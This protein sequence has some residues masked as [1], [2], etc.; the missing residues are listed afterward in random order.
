MMKKI[1]FSLMLTCAAG[2]AH[3]DDYTYPYLVLVSDDGTQT[4]LAVEQLELTFSDGLLVAKNAAGT[5][6]FTLSQLRKMAFSDSPGV[7]DAINTIDAQSANDGPADIYT[8]S[9]IHAGTFEHVGDA[10][11]ALPKGIYIVKQKDQTYKIS[12]K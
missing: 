10:Q 11:A 3:A 6:S 8:V 7:V 2:T 5:Q 9:G 1:L 12:V 4:P